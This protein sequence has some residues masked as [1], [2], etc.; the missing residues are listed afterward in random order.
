MEKP[1]T[2]GEFV[3][4]QGIE[5]VAAEILRATNLLTTR[6]LQRLMAEQALAG[7]PLWI[8][9]DRFLDGLFFRLVSGT[10]G[11]EL[12]C[13]CNHWES[14]RNTGCLNSEG[15]FVH[16]TDLQPTK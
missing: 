15:K 11:L 3:V 2:Y 6:M 7:K 13:N 9:A 16:Y 14:P 8:E 5:P 4:L 12:H 10:V 1:K